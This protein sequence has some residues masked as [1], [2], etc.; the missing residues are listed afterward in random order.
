MSDITETA[1]ITDFQIGDKGTVPGW[2]STAFR[3]V[4]FSRKRYGDWVHAPMRDMVDV[5]LDAGGLEGSYLPGFL[6]AAKTS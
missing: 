4:G 2:G 1:A 5:V 3:V 6:T